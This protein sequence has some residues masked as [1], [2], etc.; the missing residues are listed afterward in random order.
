MVLLLVALI[1]LGWRRTSPS[2]WYVAPPVLH[3][4]ALLLVG[5]GF[6]VMGASNRNSRMRLYIRHPQLTGVALWGVSHLMMNGDSRSVALFGGLVGA[7]VAL[8]LLA[9]LFLFPAL[10][11]MVDR[12]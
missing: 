5:I 6:I 1:I 8:A 4:P 7:A 12:K 10:I 11:T 9:D 3:L 2:L